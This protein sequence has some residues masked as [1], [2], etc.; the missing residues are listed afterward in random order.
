G[1]PQRMRGRAGLGGGVPGTPATVSE[2]QPAAGAGTSTAVSPLSISRGR[3]ATRAH[4]P[5]I[6]DVRSNGRR[7]V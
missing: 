7:A 2:G 1:S 5:S 4:S 3:R 6:R